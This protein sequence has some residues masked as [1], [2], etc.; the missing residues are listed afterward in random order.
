[1]ASSLYT[2]KR[3]LLFTHYIAPETGTERLH[4]QSHTASMWW[5][6]GVTPA[7]RDVKSPA[8]RSTS[9]LCLGL[10][11]G[12]ERLSKEITS[13]MVHTYP[14]EE[15]HSSSSIFFF[16]TVLMKSKSVDFSAFLEF[17]P[18]SLLS[19]GFLVCA[20]CLSS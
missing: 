10:T 13:P 7:H 4:T 9:R 12:L 8:Y 2:L 5:G 18:D 19:N 11:G 15:I 16:C 6:H 14:L 3:L 20:F 17:C 1:M